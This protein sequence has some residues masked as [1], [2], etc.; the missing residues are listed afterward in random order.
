[1]D[2]AK[3]EKKKRNKDLIIVGVAVT[4]IISIAVIAVFVIANIIKF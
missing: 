4:A 3:M 2:K 1:M